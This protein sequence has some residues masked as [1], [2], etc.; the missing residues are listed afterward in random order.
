VPAAPV[1]P[2]CRVAG[3]GTSRCGASAESCCVS[4]SLPAGTYDRTYTNDGTA[5]TGRA[6]PAQLSAF[7][8]DTYLVTVGRFRQFVAATVAG[9]APAP[10]SG[11]HTHLNGGQGLANSG[12]PGYE[13][14]WDDVDASFL[15][16][17]DAEWT[18][19][20]NCVPSFQTWTDTVGHESLPR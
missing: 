4:P 6:D 11:K 19:R 5:V 17:T 15:A 3:A 1:P 7:R 20:L 13:P 9:W 12:G 18:S 16:S 8:L 10:G 14:G 2:S